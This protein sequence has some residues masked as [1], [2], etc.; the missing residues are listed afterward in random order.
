MQIRNKILLDL[1]ASYYPQLLDTEVL[2]EALKRLPAN[3][4]LE[5][6]FSRSGP[7]LPPT[8][9]RKNVGERIKEL[10]RDQK[11]LAVRVEA[12]QKE[13]EKT[14]EGKEALKNWKDGKK[15]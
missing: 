10:E 7:G 3:M 12:I 2:L 1:Y 15:I 14:P 13:L 9:S 8:I 6:K 4:E 11:I 5:P